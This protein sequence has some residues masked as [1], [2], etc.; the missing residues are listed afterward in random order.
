MLT[1]YA[2]A[3]DERIQRALVAGYLCEARSS[4]L[5]IRHCSCNYVP[6][7]Y[8]WMDLPDIA[9]AIAPRRLI[10]QSGKKDAIFPIESVRRAYDK[11]ERV[12][13]LYGA[14]KNL[15]LHVHSGYHS[16]QSGSLNELFAGQN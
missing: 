1:M 15:Q 7:L 4:I 16:F 2:A 6:S 3:V 12:Y 5:P 11:V 14:E 13:R 10:V 9:G 8:Q